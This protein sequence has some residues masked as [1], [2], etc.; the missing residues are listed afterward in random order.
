MSSFVYIFPFVK[1]ICYT[2]AA[3][4]TPSEELKMLLDLQCSRSPSVA[5]E[6]NRGRWT[7]AAPECLTGG[8]TCCVVVFVNVRVLF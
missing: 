7:L 3:S 6:V 8:R 2:W 1:S 5:E 4:L